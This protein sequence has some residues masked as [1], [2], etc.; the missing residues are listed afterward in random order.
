MHEQ[1]KQVYTPSH[2]EEEKKYSKLNCTRWKIDKQP[3]ERMKSNEKVVR[4][5]LPIQVDITGFWCNG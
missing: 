3:N 2:N 5:A 4:A 1:Q